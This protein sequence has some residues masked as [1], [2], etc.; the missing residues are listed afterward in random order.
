[1]GHCVCTTVIGGIIGA[2]LGCV[3][4]PGE[5]TGYFDPRYSEPSRFHMA[6]NGTD[7][8]GVRCSLIGG[9]EGG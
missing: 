7:S 2:T 8:D 9:T 4:A 3:R 1:V 5:P 6:D